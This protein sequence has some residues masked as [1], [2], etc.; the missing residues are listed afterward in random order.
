MTHAPATP[1]FAA[2]FGSFAAMRT[3]G[4]RREIALAAALA[5]TT[6]REQWIDVYVQQTGEGRA[7]ADAALERALRDDTLPTPAP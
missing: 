7:E 2:D 4:T 5:L 3:Q 6:S 1:D